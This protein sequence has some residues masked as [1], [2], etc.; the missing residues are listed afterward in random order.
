MTLEDYEL[1]KSRDIAS[2]MCPADLKDRAESFIWL[3]EE[4]AATGER[5]GEKLADLTRRTSS[6]IF[7]YSAVHNTAAASNYKPQEFKGL[8]ANCHIS[9]GAPVLLIS[10]KLFG[11]Y[12]VPLRLMNGSRG[13]AVAIFQGVSRPPPALPD[14]VVVDIPGYRGGPIFPGIGRETWVPVPPVTV[15]EKTK[16]DASR[17]AI[18]LIL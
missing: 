6:A 18:P 13:T 12:T 14:C 15:M 2:D 3:C 9:V 4:N 16:Q 1:W 5:N 10:N 11:V 8:R 7:R 17:T